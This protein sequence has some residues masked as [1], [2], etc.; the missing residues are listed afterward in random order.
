MQ[1][2]SAIGVTMVHLKNIILYIILVL[3]TP[4]SL[5]ET[6]KYTGNW[7]DSTGNPIKTSFG[8]CIRAGDYIRS[9]SHIECFTGTNT[10]EYPPVSDT[11]PEIKGSLKDKI[12]SN[13][14]SPYTN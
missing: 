8:E 7:V 13:P 12:P 5:T 3:H 1:E 14:T 2:I 11:Y 4:L 10:S 6:L 9:N